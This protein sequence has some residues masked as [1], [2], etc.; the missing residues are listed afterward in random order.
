M[1]CESCPLTETPAPALEELIGRLRGCD[2]CPALHGEDARA[3]TRRLATALCDAGR[4]IRQLRSKLRQGEGERRE[5]IAESERYEQHIG[6]LER[7]HRSSARELEEQLAL[8][9][10]QAQAIREL[11]APLMEVGEGVLAIVIIGIQDSE[12]AALITTALLDRIQRSGSREVIVDLT[13]LEALTPE[14]A[15]RLGQMMASARLL[16][17]RVHV[18]GIRPALARALV[19]LGVELPAAAIVRSVREALRRLRS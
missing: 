18:S 13:S 1:R 15:A 5:L 19:E 12:H 6:E 3:P 17:A 2:E 16:G 8:V 10:E 14:S 11:S 9:G 7:L 4:L